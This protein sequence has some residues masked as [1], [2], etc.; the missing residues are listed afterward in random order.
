MIPRLLTLGRGSGGRGGGAHE[1]SNGSAV[2]T[3]CF[4][5]GAK[6]T[7]K[8]VGDDAFVVEAVLEGGSTV[9]KKMTPNNWYSMIARPAGTKEFEIAILSLSGEEKWVPHSAVPDRSTAV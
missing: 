7:G 8:P 2:R 6:C 4:C 1:A 5:G 9:G 3:C